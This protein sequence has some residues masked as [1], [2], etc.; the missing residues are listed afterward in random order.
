MAANI[1]AVRVRNASG[2]ASVT[3]KDLPNEM[4]AAVV[5][6][7]TAKQVQRL[8]RVSKYFCQFIDASSN[9]ATIFKPIASNTRSFNELAQS[10]VATDTGFLEQF[11]TFLEHRG[12][13]SDQYIDDDD[14]VA[15]KNQWIFTRTNTWTRGLRDSVQI[16]AMK[17]LRVHLRKRIPDVFDSRHGGNKPIDELK[18]SLTKIGNTIKRGDSIGLSPVD[19]QS[20]IDQFKREGIFEGQTGE[21]YVRYDDVRDGENLPDWHITSLRECRMICPPLCSPEGLKQLLSVDIPSAT[22]SGD[23]GVIE[24]FYAYCVRNEWAYKKIQSATRGETLD[25]KTKARIMDELYI[26]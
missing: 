25:W 13:Q 21:Q 15:F 12:I 9:D 2:A 18:L 10:L 7:M 24:G 1:A 11:R 3:M 20:I 26:W 19:V 23:Y 22:V 16:F 8:R 4:I 6:H 5:S 17:L 14:I